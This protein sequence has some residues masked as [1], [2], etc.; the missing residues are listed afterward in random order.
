MSTATRRHSLAPAEEHA[1]DHQRGECRRPDPHER[2]RHFPNREPGQ[3]GVDRSRL[4]EDARQSGA[5]APVRRQPKGLVAGATDPRA[6]QDEP[7][8]ETRWLRGQEDRQVLPGDQGVGE[9]RASRGRT[10]PLE[11]RPAPPSAPAARSARRR[12]T[13]QRLRPRT[14]RNAHPGSSNASRPSNDA[15][16]VLVEVHEPDASSAAESPSA[17]L[18]SPERTSSPTNPSGPACAARASFPCFATASCA[19]AVRSCPGL[20]QQKID[21]YPNGAGVE[22]RP[23]AVATG[24][25]ISASARFSSAREA[26][27]V[28]DQQARIGGAHRGECQAG[29]ERRP[30]ER[31]D[32][33][34]R[35][36]RWSGQ[37]RAERHAERQDQPPGKLTF[38]PASDLLTAC[39]CRQLPAPEQRPSEAVP[40]ASC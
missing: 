14:G 38:V 13:S 27:S 18:T 22:D 37:V 28:Y 24:S 30:L 39:D 16:R 11:S 7:A 3:D 35:A 32:R 10:C 1:G 17:T 6:E 4:D 25:A 15:V 23:S 19:K 5:A 34:E 9:R 33:R 8:L 36:D 29:I 2:S 20:R 26:S 31:S 40:P 12:A 21:G